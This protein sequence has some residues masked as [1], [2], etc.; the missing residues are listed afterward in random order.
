MMGVMNVIGDYIWREGLQGSQAYAAPV[1]QG[2]G[3]RSGLIEVRGV[4]LASKGGDMK[5]EKEKRGV[6]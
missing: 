3:V 5:I 6:V 4:E 2:V 1:S